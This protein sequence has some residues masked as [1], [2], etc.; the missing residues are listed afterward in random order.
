MK[1]AAFYHL[2]AFPVRLS[3]N[4]KSDP[5]AGLEAGHK[6]LLQGGISMFMEELGHKAQ[7]D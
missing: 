7:P 1:V 5:H 6:K 2:N 4:M 3:V